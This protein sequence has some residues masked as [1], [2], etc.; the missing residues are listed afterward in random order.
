MQLKNDM[1]QAEV[2]FEKARLKKLEEEEKKKENQANDI[3]PKKKGPK[4]HFR[5]SKKPGRA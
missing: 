4:T 5:K 1:A 2:E 3:K